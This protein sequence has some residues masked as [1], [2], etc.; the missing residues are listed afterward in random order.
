VIKRFAASTGRHCIRKRVDGLFLR[1]ASHDFYA[2][3][4]PMFSS[5]PVH[6]WQKDASFACRYVSTAWMMSSDHF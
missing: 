5:I 1:V 2:L 4:P 3:S 6:S